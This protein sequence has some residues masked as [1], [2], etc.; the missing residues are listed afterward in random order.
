[1][2]P[3]FPLSLMLLGALSGR[4]DTGSTAT[5]RWSAEGLQIVFPRAM[6][7]DLVG[8]DRTVGGR[9]SGYEWRVAIEDRNGSARMVAFVIPPDQET[10]RISRFGTIEEAV[11][12]GRSHVRICDRVTGTTLRCARP[13]AAVVRLNE[14]RLEI[15]ITEVR[16]LVDIAAS[17]EPVIHLAVRRAGEPVWEETVP[18][19]PEPTPWH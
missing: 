13:A 2:I 12:A 8:V 15:F 18:V 6:S 17:A 9:F 19:V 3:P 7:P 1:M 11:R 5:A 16:W 14:R 10:L 4:V